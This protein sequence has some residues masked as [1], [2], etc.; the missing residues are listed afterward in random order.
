MEQNHQ[1]PAL[2]SRVTVRLHGGVRRGEICRVHESGRFDV[3]VAN[4]EVYRGVSP[5]QIRRAG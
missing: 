1:T 5:R 4:G 3:R 2:E